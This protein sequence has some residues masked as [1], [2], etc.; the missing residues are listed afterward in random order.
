MPHQKSFC[1][2]DDTLCHPLTLAGLTWGSP[3]T[4]KDE[5]HLRRV[6]PGTNFAL[7]N[8]SVSQFVFSHSLLIDH[9]FLTRP[10][11]KLSAK[12]YVACILQNN[13]PVKISED[14]GS[15]RT[16]NQ[17]SVSSF[18]TPSFSCYSCLCI[19]SQILLHK[20]EM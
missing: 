11:F 17:Y 7:M 13:F 4:E 10:L 14:K 9:S 2:M 5:L 3:C 16:Y 20:E 1:R 6:R 18:T 19:H 15:R 12:G 8:L